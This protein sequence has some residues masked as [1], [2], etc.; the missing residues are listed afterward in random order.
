MN[1][2][3]N[4]CDEELYDRSEFSSTF[5]T[6]ES[7][8]AVGDTLIMS[9]SLSSQIE[10]EFSETTY[11]NTNQL[12]NYG[13]EIFEGRENNNDAI[14]AREKFEFIDLKGN[15]LIPEARTWE[16][17]IENTCDEN[18][19]ELEFGLIPQQAGYYG[20]LLRLGNFGITNDCQY[21]TLWPSEIE[22]GGNNNFEIFN[23]INLSSIR[24]DGAF[25]ANPELENLLYFIKV[26]E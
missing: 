20:F 8:I 26:S 6:L 12:I 15:V 16:I 9:T 21:L 19:C 18:L 1:F 17:N 10:L 4:D 7:T 14:Q 22:S 23:E 24:V 2:Q 5:N 3:C 13:L 11:D 25:F